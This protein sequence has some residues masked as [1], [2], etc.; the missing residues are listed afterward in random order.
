MVAPAAE[1]A[2][3]H[4]PRRTVWLAAAAALLLTGLDLGSKAWAEEALSRPRVGDAPA[5]CVASED[6]FIPRQ[7][8]PRLPIVFVEDVFDLEYAENCGAAFGLLRQAPA[9]V[10]QV[11]FGLAALLA[12]G[13]LFAMLA[14][15]RGGP[16]F[17]AAVPLVAA[18][19]AGNLVDRVRYGYVV[20][21]IH[22]HWGESF[23]YPTFNVADI[24]ITVGVLCWILDAIQGGRPAAPVPSAP[25]APE[26]EHDRDVSEAP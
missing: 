1:I 15:G 25:P 6:G 24:A 13:A 7:R 22:L 21:F 16:Y 10:R 2:A 8:L 14:R 9:R 20:D 11:V 26:P 12:C 17:V 18:G 23:D 4:R 5:V 19:A 3:V